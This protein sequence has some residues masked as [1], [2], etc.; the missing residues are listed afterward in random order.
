[1]KDLIRLEIQAHQEMLQVEAVTAKIDQEP[2]DL[3]EL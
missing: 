2:K 3:K 1:M